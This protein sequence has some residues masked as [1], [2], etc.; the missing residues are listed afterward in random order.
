MA[1]LCNMT[2]KCKKVKPVC[3][4]EMLVVGAVAVL[5]AYVALVA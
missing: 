1:V 2:K 3:S 4:H 5:V